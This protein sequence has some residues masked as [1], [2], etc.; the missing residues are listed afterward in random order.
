MLAHYRTDRLRSDNGTRFRRPA[1]IAADGPLEL[2]SGFR[3]LHGEN[4]HGAPASPAP[5]AP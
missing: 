3:D 4:L 5:R 2:K 1:P